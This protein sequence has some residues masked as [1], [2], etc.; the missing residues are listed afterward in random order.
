M[1]LSGLGNRYHRCAGSSWRSLPTT[2]LAYASF[3]GSA[4]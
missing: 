3:K 1:K 4:Q 2:A